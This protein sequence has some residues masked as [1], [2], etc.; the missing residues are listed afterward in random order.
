MKI[1]IDDDGDVVGVGE[2]EEAARRDA[3]DLIKSDRSYIRGMVSGMTCGDAT[4]TLLERIKALGGGEVICIHLGKGIF[5]T[6]DE[7]KKRRGPP[8]A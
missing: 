5:G 4:D 1:I 3:E 6:V 2:T 8:P 7:A